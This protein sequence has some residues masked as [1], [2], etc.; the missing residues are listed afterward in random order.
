MVDPEFVGLA[1][2]VGRQ[3]I[4]I[5]QLENENESL[6]AELEVLKKTVR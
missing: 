6:K 5:S 4:A 1:K 3:Q 2:L